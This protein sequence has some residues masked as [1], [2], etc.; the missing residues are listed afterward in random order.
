MLETKAKLKKMFFNFLL[1][2]FGWVILLAVFGGVVNYIKSTAVP[3]RIISQE[4]ASKVYEQYLVDNYGFDQLG[5]SPLSSETKCI[6]SKDD[7]KRVGFWGEKTGNYFN[8]FG[9]PIYQINY[10]KYDNCYKAE[11]SNY[12]KAIGNDTLSLNTLENYFAY[13]DNAQV[14]STPSFQQKVAQIKTDGK[15]TVIE[16]LQTNKLYEQLN[17]NFRY[18]SLGAKTSNSQKETL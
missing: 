5:F 8:I 15:V 11:I 17:A 1:P 3:N 13:F 10:A 16:L 9:D 6:I 7:I 4:R 18:Q 2:L 14:V 12:I